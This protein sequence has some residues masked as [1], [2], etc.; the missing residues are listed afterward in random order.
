MA[1][2]EGA[3]PQ[4]I[5]DEEQVVCILSPVLQHFDRQGPHPPICKLVLLVRLRAGPLN[6]LKA[7]HPPRMQALPHNRVQT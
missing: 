4:F 3:H 6:P 5:I 7:L 1:Q 2:F